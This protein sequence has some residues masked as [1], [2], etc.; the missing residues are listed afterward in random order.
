M[1][2]WDSKPDSVGLMIFDGAEELD[3][4][5]PWEM[6]TMWREYA[7][8]PEIIETVAHKGNPVRCGKGLTVIPDTHFSAAR[9]YD[10]L[11]VPGGFAAFDIAEDP[12]HLDF[13]RRQ[14]ANA[15]AMLSVCTGSMILCAAG[16]L[17]GKSATTHWKAMD[18]L[19]K[20]SNVSA[21][22]ARYV[23]DGRIWTSAGVSAG[24][25]MSLAFISATAGEEAARIV[26]LN[27]EYYPEGCMF[28]SP[29]KTKFAPAYVRQPES[30]PES[31]VAK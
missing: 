14:S 6:F 2:S 5:G 12:I 15:Q 20:F 28:G 29:E 17:A 27:S 30:S 9:N 7:S 8:G 16:L 25:D 11:L 18:R 26:Q 3:F 21:T 1:T 19:S 31:F 4:I 10:V 24:I 23:R 13:V 22:S